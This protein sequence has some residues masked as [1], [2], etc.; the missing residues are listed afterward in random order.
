[1]RAIAIAHPLQPF[2]RRYGG[3]DPRLFTYAAEYARREPPPAPPR[4][5][6]RTLPE[7]ESP[8]AILTMEVLGRFLAN[9]ARHF[10]ERRL[11]LRLDAAEGP[12]EGTEPFSLVQ[13]AGWEADQRAFSLRRAGHDADEVHS[14]LRAAGMLP[15]GAAG[16]AAL[17]RRLADIEPIVDALGQATFTAPV[18]AVLEIP[19]T[20]PAM[21]FAV[22]LHDLT[23]DG[24]IAWRIGTLR[25]ADRLR[26]WVAHLALAALAPA[27]VALRTRLLTRTETILF[28]APEHPMAQ[29]TALVELYVR[30]GTG[31]LPFFPETALA[32]ATGLAKGEEAAWRAAEERWIKERDSNAYFS[33]AFRDV[34][35]LDDRFAEHARAIYTPM[36][37]AENRDA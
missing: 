35:P 13:L 30:G 31:P 4:F 3:D 25:A 14:V 16:D 20:M 22:T 7:A 19:G 8:A 37:A 27:G 10:F 26:A 11:G 12:L 9:P 29:L 21:R 33:L 5:A 23:P 2:S 28:G 36:L 34:D 17:A 32:F 18:E 6:G 15:D 1:M 24:Q